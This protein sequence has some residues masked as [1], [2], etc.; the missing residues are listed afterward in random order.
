[1]GTIASRAYN[2]KDEEL[3]VICR[4]TAFSF[5]QDLA[6]FQAYSPIYNPEYLANF[7]QRIASAEA[8]MSP[9]SEA[10][11]RKKKSDLLIGTIT[12][13]TTPLNHLHGNL[14]LA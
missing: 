10:V 11:T 9:K 12:G 1:M 7:K 3:P 6:V 13:L 8:L 2:C 5:E 4:F 14:N